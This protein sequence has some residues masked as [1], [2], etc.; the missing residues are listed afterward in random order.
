MKIIDFISSRGKRH[1]AMPSLK[2]GADDD[3]DD[4]D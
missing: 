2:G 3:G 4:E 1:F